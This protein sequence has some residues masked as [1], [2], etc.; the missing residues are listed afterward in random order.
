MTALIRLLALFLSLLG[1]FPAAQAEMVPGAT[2]AAVPEA[3][4]IDA[5]LRQ[6]ETDMDLGR[7]KLT[8]DNMIDPTM[9]VESGLKQID[10]MATRV[11]A[12]LYD[13]PPSGA[14]LK[15]LRAY[16]YE[17]GPWNDYRS[18][19]YDFD[20][21]LGKNI[22]NKLLLNY[23][24]SRRGNCVTMP[25]LFFILGQRLGLDV[26]ISAAPLH[27]F[28][29]Y[30]DPETGTTYNLETT[31]GAKPARDV[32]IRQGNPMTDQAIANGLYMRKLSIQT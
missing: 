32:W 26:T 2:I 28:V 22:R 25:L 29:N 19:G 9:D 16:L 24:A 21:P 14:R 18:F 23:I 15:A 8:I 31:S 6:P 7:I 3:K 12:M 20:D 27:L 10:E 11:R 17:K 1:S 13:F 30:T 4:R 5:I